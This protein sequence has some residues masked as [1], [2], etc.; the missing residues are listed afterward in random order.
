MDIRQT[1]TLL[2]KPPALHAAGSERA[3]QSVALVAGVACAQQDCFV[4]AGGQ[5]AAAASGAITTAGRYLR[6]QCDQDFT[7][8]FGS[9]GMG[10]PV[11]GT[12]WPL[13]ALEIYDVWIDTGETPMFRAISASNATVWFYLG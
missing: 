4:A 8:A 5:A 3:V 12:D 10:A 6:F 1:V 2:I 13:R 11:I 9:A 7:I